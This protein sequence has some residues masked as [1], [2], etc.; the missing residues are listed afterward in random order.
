MDAHK[1][2]IFP[3]NAL[4]R[5]KRDSFHKCLQLLFL[6]SILRIFKESIATPRL[7]TSSALF[8]LH[9]YISAAF[10]LLRS[11]P[12][13]TLRRSTI[14]LMTNASLVSTIT[15]S[16]LHMIFAFKTRSIYVDAFITMLTFVIWIVLFEWPN[17][18]KSDQVPTRSLHRN[19]SRG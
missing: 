15:H 2:I 19:E 5:L 4:F 16:F 9:I 3:S 6:F 10:C 1:D 8:V 17:G 12:V 11:F 18:E 14:S 13:A 7:L